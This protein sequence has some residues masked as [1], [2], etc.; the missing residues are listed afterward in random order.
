MNE[1]AA[2]GAL[3]T[4]DA[5]LEHFLLYELDDDW[6]P[7]GSF[8][9]IARRVSPDDCS[10]DRVAE[11]IEEFAR[12]GLMTIGGWSTDTRTWERWTISLPEAMQRIAD[13]DGLNVGYRSATEQQL[14]LTE[15]FRGEITTAGKLLLAELG[16]PYE[17][18]GDP[19]A[20]EGILAA[21][22]DFPPW[23]Q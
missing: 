2:D 3:L 5:R 4:I 23:Q 6:M 18:Y 7:L 19:W 8:V 20:G 13:G 11:V 12:R 17:K 9:G 1:K 16:S 10:L 14:G 22:G 21:E 15:V